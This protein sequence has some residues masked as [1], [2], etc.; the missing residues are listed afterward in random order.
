MRMS[1]IIPGVVV[2][3]CVTAA[4]TIDT[5]ATEPLPEG[6]RSRDIGRVGVSGSSSDSSAQ[7]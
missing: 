2:L 6:W 4:G 7:S 5:T 3:V 1:K